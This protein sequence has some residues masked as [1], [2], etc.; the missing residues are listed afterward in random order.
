LNIIQNRFISKMPNWEIHNKWTSK[1]GIDPLIANFVDRN[2]DYGT[3]WAFNENQQFDEELDEPI[4][5]RQLKFFYKKD[6]E[7]KYDNDLLY[8]KAYYLHHFLDF[9]KETR[10]SLDDL[11]KIFFEFLKKKVFR[12]FINEDQ[13]VINFDKQIFEIKEIIKKNK[14]ELI[15]DLR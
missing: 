12:E 10:F 3:E 7:K 4:S 5:L 15:N 8:V 11:D 9:L 14:Q 13:E 1:A 2:I 6:L